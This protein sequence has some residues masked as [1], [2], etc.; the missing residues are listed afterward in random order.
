[1]WFGPSGGQRDGRSTVGEPVQQRG[2]W[3]YLLHIL[4]DEVELPPA[5]ERL[6][7]LHDV[8]LLQCAEHL[9]LP[10][11]GLLDLLILWRRS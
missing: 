5:A 3:T 1:M 9:Q 10:Q 4:E 2:P 11:R 8:L 6:L 7:Q